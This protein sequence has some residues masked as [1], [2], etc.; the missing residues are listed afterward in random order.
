MTTL[1]ST[2]EPPRRKPGRPRQ[3]IKHGTPGGVRAHY[4][5]K[6]AMCDEC[7]TIERGNRPRRTPPQCGT[8]SG[9]KDHRDRDE[10]ACQRCLD[11][12]AADVEARAM[13]RRGDQWPYDLLIPKVTELTENGWTVEEI[14]AWL[15]VSKLRVGRAKARGREASQ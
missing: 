13:A 6:V 9:Y 15:N 8:A 4:R 10:P 1:P 2:V 12:H 5:H 3:P 11:A 7:K 14:A